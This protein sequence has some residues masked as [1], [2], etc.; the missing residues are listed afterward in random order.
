MWKWN[1]GTSKN[2]ITHSG[3][4]RP[5]SR[6][7]LMHWK[8]IKKERINGKW[9]YYYDNPAARDRGTYRYDGPVPKD[10]GYVSMIQTYPGQR[11]VDPV[12]DKY[13]QVKQASRMKAIA[14]E[15]NRKRS[16]DIQPLLN[17]DYNTLTDSEKKDLQAKT[18]ALAQA[19][20]SYKTAAE[21]YLKKKK[22]FLSTPLGAL[23]KIGD[24]VVSWFKKLFG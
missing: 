17:K 24:Q 22:D 18:N 3:L 9:R 5:L 7:E 15:R 8:Y 12:T 16:D 2:Y 23:K 20:A 4:G 11:S 21:N 14:E 10:P 1:D 6:D 13:G 19:N